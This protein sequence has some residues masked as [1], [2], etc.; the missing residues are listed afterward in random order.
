MS[1]RDV[2]Y[3]E[4]YVSGYDNIVKDFYQPSLRNAFEYWR[5]VGYFSSSALESF[6]APLG[7][8]VKKDGN[9]RLV[10]SVELSEPDLRAIEN[11][12]SKREICEARL[13]EVID[14][15]FAD[16]IGDGVT[17][18][19]RLLELGRLEIRIAIPKTGTGI[20]HEKI[21]LFFDERDC[22]AF[23]G[24]SNESVNAFEN[25][26]ECIDVYTSWSAPS[27]TERK[28]DHFIRIW[29]RT[30]I[31]VEVF[32]FPEAAKRRLLRVS[33]KERSQKGQV[34]SERSK[35]RHQDEA[36]ATFIDAE[37]GILNMAT[38]TGKT[39]TALQI[40]DTLFRR[41]DIET[42]I[43]AM[44]G[45][46]LLRQWYR[47][48]LGLRKVADYPVQLYRDFDIHKEVQDFNLSPSGSILLTSR[49][50]GPAR[51]PLRSALQNLPAGDRTLL[52]HDE[53]H[54]LGSPSNRRRFEGL[55]E[56]IR[57]RLGLSATP[58]REYDEDGNDFIEG[59]IGPTLMTFGLGDAIKRGILAPFKYYPL[60]YEATEADKARLRDVY[61]K[62][63]ARAEAGNPMTDEEVWIDIARVYKTSRAKIP[64][65]D[66]LLRAEPDLLRRSIVFVETQEYGNEVLDVIHK[67]RPD[68]HTYFT[69]QNSQVLKRF[70][71]GELECLVTCH[72]LSEGIDIRS[73]N[74]VVLFS[75]A[76]A[77]LETIQRIGRCLR[78]DPDNPSKVANIVDF[79]RL[80]EDGNLTTDDS[81][82][83]WLQELSQI[84]GEE[85]G[86]V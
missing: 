31:G 84:R 13:I 83:A 12:S 8:F 23:T 77:R 26:R 79:V 28:R 62:K 81:R 38:G 57:Y 5:A 24:S 58:E 75:S 33:T 18:L 42:A 19:T 60:S 4:D 22:V 25:N 66:Q 3:Q 86:L 46:D 14:G 17:R 59:H 30:D 56:D 45:D 48:L 32:D 53:V 15:E 73:L 69:G 21:G 82:R 72:R 68:F 36:I 27:R 20:Y 11:G 54:R 51:D 61:K 6:G 55:S 67:Y 65:F 50:A 37:R 47:E 76:R 29:D 43:I 78:A 7:E 80:S 16:G 44:D 35:W 1:L 52:V 85:G 71:Q 70:A 74:T 10:T 64:L 34:T 49:A 2:P 63:A 9:I 39:R 41:R 40:M